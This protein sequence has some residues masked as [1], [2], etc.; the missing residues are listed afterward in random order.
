M[1]TKKFLAMMILCAAFS[2]CGG[3]NDDNDV[4]ISNKNIFGF[5]GH[6]DSSSR[7]IKNSNKKN[8]TSEKETENIPE[9]PEEISEM[10]LY[11][12]AMQLYDTWIMGRL[13]G[14]QKKAES[15]LCP[16]KEIREW[17]D[18]YS[19]LNEYY[20]DYQIVQF[21]VTDISED[22]EKHRRDNEDDYDGFPEIARG[23]QLD[24]Q[25]MLFSPDGSYEDDTCSDAILEIDGKLYFCPDVGYFKKIEPERIGFSCPTLDLDVESYGSSFSYDENGNIID[26]SWVTFTDGTKMS[27][28]E[29]DSLYEDSLVTVYGYSVEKKPD[30]T[31]SFHP[32]SV[33]GKVIFD[34]GSTAVVNGARWAEEEE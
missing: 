17:C 5:G 27:E 4:D 8:A 28:E 20:N 33:N 34:D 9:V 16:N 32:V 2:G 11:N 7:E 22:I 10:E 14:N 23:W 1:K 18:E 3:N 21:L 15:V 19:P 24:S 6:E 25:L 30:G 29:Y 12:I 13:D 26:K 31:F